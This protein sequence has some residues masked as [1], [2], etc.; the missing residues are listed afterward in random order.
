[1][2]EAAH[3]VGVAAGQHVGEMRRRRSAS[4]CGRRRTAI[5]ARPRSR[6]SPRAARGNCRNCRSVRA[7]PRRNGAA[8][9]RGGS[10]APRPRRRARSA[11]RARPARRSGSTSVSIRRRARAKSSAPQNSQAS[12]GSPSRPGAAGLLV[13]SL[14]RLGDAGMGD[15]AHVGLVDAHAE[16]DRRD[17]HHVLG[18]R[19][20][21]PGCAARTCGSSPAW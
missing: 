14:D 11:A 4:R 10:S 3:L 9:S 19:R 5:C 2:A 18:L 1:M 7:G 15:E 16:G 17:D 13:I 12:A 21:P 20:T 8:G 6:R